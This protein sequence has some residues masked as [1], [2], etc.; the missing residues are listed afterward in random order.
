M[1]LR[2]EANHLDLFAEQAQRGEEILAL[3]D[4][5]TQ[6]LLGVQHEHGRVH[7]LSVR[8]R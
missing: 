1:A 3:L 6:I 5:A 2:R 8:G 7:L 4:V